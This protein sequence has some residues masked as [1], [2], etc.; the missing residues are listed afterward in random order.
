MR[1][2]QGQEFV[3]GGYTIRGATF[4]VL[5]FSYYDGDSKREEL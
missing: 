2:D 1:V 5:V 4:D 3:I